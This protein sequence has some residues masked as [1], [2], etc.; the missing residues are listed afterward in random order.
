MPRVVWG[1]LGLVLGYAAGVVIGGAL[2]TLFSGNT[3]DKSVEMAT[4][5]LLITGPIGAI[6][7]LVLGVA[8][9]AS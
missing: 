5:A 7:G 6:L 3:H 2:V 1:A 4:T 8:R 9:K